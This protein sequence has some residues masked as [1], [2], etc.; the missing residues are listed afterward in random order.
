[1]AEHP[2][3]QPKRV[4]LKQPGL[5]SAPNKLLGGQEGALLQAQNLVS[6]SPGELSTR[7]GFQA[8][9]YDTSSGNYV[10]DA[11]EYNQGNTIYSAQLPNGTQG[12]L[13]FYAPG[14]RPIS[15]GQ[16]LST[17]LKNPSGNANSNNGGR[18]LLNV[19]KGVM[20]L[21]GSLPQFWIDQAQLNAGQVIPL[22]I[23]KPGSTY[24]SLTSSMLGVAPNGVDFSNAFT[25]NTGQPQFPLFNYSAFASPVNL[26]GTSTGRATNG[27]GCAYRIVYRW[28]LAD[29]TSI[30]SPPSDRITVSYVAVSSTNTCTSPGLWHAVNRDGYPLLGPNFYVQ[31][32]R[33]LLVTG[34]YTG[35]SYS[36]DY[37]LVGEISTSQITPGTAG[38]YTA[39]AQWASVGL[40]N[41][42][43]Q[44]GV[45]QFANASF[46]S[47][48]PLVPTALFMDN[49]PDAFAVNP[50]YTNATDGQGTTASAIPAPLSNSAAFYYGRSYFGAVTQP[51]TVT[52]QLIGVA[53]A[54]GLKGG[55]VVAVCGVPFT[56]YSLTGLGG[57]PANLPTGQNFV[58]WDLTTQDTPT[59]CIQQTGL[60]F[61]KAVNNY[62]L[63]RTSTASSASWEPLPTVQ[64]TYAST[65]SQLPGI[66]TFTA[67]QCG[68][69]AGI[70]LTVT[71]FSP[72]PSGATAWSPTINPAAVSASP[73]YSPGQLAFSDV[74]APWMA[75]QNSYTTVGQLDKAILALVGTR[76]SLFVFK[77]DGLF[78]LN[79]TDPT[80][81]PFLPFDPT[82]R[83]VGPRTCQPFDNNVVCLCERG[84]LLITEAG[85]SSISID[86]DDL[87]DGYALPPYRANYAAGAFVVPVESQNFFLLFLPG[88]EGQAPCDFA[89]LHNTKTNTWTT[90]KVRGL[91]NI[92]GVVGGNIDTTS[93]QIR[94]FNYDQAGVYAAGAGPYVERLNDDNTDYADPDFNMTGTLASAAGVVTL[95]ETDALAW[96]ERGI[97]QPGDNVYGVAGGALGT[98]V[99]VVSVNAAAG[100]AVLSG[101]PGTG[102]T[103]T[104]FVVSPGVL[105]V[106]QWLPQ[107]SEDPFTG[108]KWRYAY[109]SMESCSYDN[110]VAIFRSE[111]SVPETAPLVG[112]PT[113][114]WG[115]QGGTVAW[116]SQQ[117][118]SPNQSPWGRNGSDRFEQVGVTEN[119]THSSALY[120]TFFSAQWRRPIT[121]RG[122]SVSA[123]QAGEMIEE[124][125]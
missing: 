96:I 72:S 123:E 4:F 50:L 76:D 124:I 84:V 81:T 5:K 100:T 24:V 45:A 18:R 78:R 36:E 75:R 28:Q 87:L 10:N 113:V 54:T 90:T 77:E 82:L 48:G 114:P 57:N 1:M 46:F 59:Q 34:Y 32:Y 99:S 2:G 26:Y 65:G 58:V 60:S 86:I 112:P 69:S 53:G 103:E 22:G 31:I 17:A 98:N 91:E 83:V 51:A 9:N 117:P 92:R 94:L 89:L 80:T 105:Q 64:A 119:A 16:G 20:A 13:R 6:R 101:A 47:G 30:Y 11:T 23:P 39:P 71:I 37:Y 66:L 62:F 95:T 104:S 55:D 121:I 38:L 108:K 118:N 111:Q 74:N 29:G 56:G 107:T 49:V 25:P 15:P 110:A 21:S 40:I 33:T 93:N 44:F 52:V 14:V 42:W 68:T 63:G 102:L 79:G 120:V 7:F 43:P 67:S 70:P 3:P 8:G 106:I 35:V 109:F 61:V 97:L 12:E 73:V 116:G 41:N 27:I 88:E 122:M 19:G 85:A 125:Q 115:S